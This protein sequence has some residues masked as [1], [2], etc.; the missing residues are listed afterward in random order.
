[1][2]FTRS[3]PQTLDYSLFTG[4]PVA[5]STEGTDTGHVF[6]GGGLKF[7]PRDPLTLDWYLY[8]QQAAGLTDRRTTGVEWRYR[9][10]KGF[11]FGAFEYDFNFNEIDH[12]NL[13]VNYNPGNDWIIN[14]NWDYRYSPLLSMINALQGQAVSSLDDFKRTHDEDEIRR[15][16]L[17][18][19]ARNQTVFM[20]ASYAIDL[21][22]L[23]SLNLSWSRSE[24][25]RASAG[26]EASPE[27]T[28]IQASA[29]YSFKGWLTRD[30]FA[31]WGLRV[32]DSDTITL[33]SLQARS[34]IG[35]RKKL[36]YTPRLRLDHRS[37]KNDPVRQW[38]L[39]PEIKV[40]YR[41]SRNLSLEGSFG[42]EYADFN[43]PELN[44]R[45][46]YSLYLS[47]YYQF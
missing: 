9:A 18:R 12:F 6:V 44:D 39:A 22:R 8:Q 29:D 23:L 33:L 13:V 27:S 14:L 37:N 19:T 35:S 41:P 10:Q 36:F 26:V 30:D 47:Y 4:F 5:A 45:T 28:E 16:A 1:V 25:T 31:T 42:F 46:A 2:V 34:R 3:D 7:R 24:A 17:D 11:L 15:I 20:G 38:I 43:L 40:S 32:S 21:N